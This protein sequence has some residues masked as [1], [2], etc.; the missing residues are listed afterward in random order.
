MDWQKLEWLPCIHRY[1]KEQRCRK[2]KRLIGNIPWCRLLDL[3]VS[4][5]YCSGCPYRE[6]AM[7]PLG[8]RG[9]EEE[10]ENQKDGSP[11]DSPAPGVTRSEP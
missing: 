2:S 6:D 11:L 9:I 7:H 5:S 4:P 10:P 1:G 8:M 3:L